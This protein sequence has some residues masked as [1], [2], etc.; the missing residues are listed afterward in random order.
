MTEDGKKRRE[1]EQLQKSNPA[2]AKTQ[3]WPPPILPELVTKKKTEP[4]KGLEG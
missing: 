4:E 3:P 2:V 1:F